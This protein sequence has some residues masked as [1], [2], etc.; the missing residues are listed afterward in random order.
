MNDKKKIYK[1]KKIYLGI[2][3]LRV[4][5]S[6][7]ILLFHCINRKIYSQKLLNNLREIV[8]IALTTFFIISFYFSYNSF[9]SK[10]IILIKQRFKRLLIPYIIWP[11]IIFFNNNFIFKKKK[12]EFK[13]LYYQILIGNGIYNVLWFN[14]NLIFISLIFIIIIFITSRFMIVL[15]FLGIIFY[16]FSSFINYNKIFMKYNEIATFTTKPIA[17]NYE[18]SLI[19]FYISSN[20]IIDKA[21]NNIKRNISFCII[22]LIALNIFYNKTKLVILYLF[23]IFL[24]ILFAII[25]FEKFENKNIYIYIRLLSS[26]TGGIYYLHTY[27]NLL[28]KEIPLFIF[29]NGTILFCFINYLICYIICFVGA[30]ILRK[31]NFKYLFI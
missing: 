23:S 2:E 27:I 19:G 5:F 28:L 20:K 14:F 30:K 13:Y 26:Y 9:T 29:I 31:S 16:L 18:N 17:I 22:L 24:F 6:F 1:R 25:P 15:I 7:N 12:F 3:I 11:I 21:H 8:K 10:N 4:F